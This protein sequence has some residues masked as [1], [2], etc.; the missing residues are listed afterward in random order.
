MK[1][2][3]VSLVS[4][5]LVACVSPAPQTRSY[6]V[7][8]GKTVSLPFAN[9]GA[10]SSQTTNVKIEVTGFMVDGVKSELI[11]TFGFTERNRKTPMRVIVEDVTNSAAVALVTDLFP[12]ISS[13]GYWKGQSSARKAG[14]ASLEWLYEPGNTEKVFR[15]TITLNDGSTEEIY[16][17]SVWPGQS[18]PV[19]KNALKL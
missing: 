3:I 13:D 7:S 4:L 12:S 10:L 9:G 15:F 17:A 6:T 8:G 5:A 1:P 11:Y 18:K 14:D 16:Q 19:I 2:I